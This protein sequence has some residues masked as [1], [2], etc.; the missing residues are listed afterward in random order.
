MSVLSPYIFKQGQQVAHDL[1]KKTERSKLTPRREP[2]WTRLEIG[3]YLGYRVMSDNVG[4]WIARRQEG[5]KKTY[6]ALGH[7]DLY[8]DAKKAALAWAGRVDAG[9]TDKAPTVQAACEHYVKHQRTAKGDNAAK[10]AEGRFKRLVYGTAFGKITLDKLNT[11]KVRAWRDGQI[12]KGDDFDDDTVRRAKDSINRN[13]ATLKA[14]LNLAHRDRLT[15]SD[16]AWKTVTSFEK[17][18][19][20]RTI[21]L[22]TDQR[23]AL[24]AQCG[25]GLRELVTA[26]LLTGIRPGE[27]AGCDVA[28]FDKI[29]GTLTIRISK[30]EARTVPLSTAAIEHFKTATKDRIGAAPLIPDGFGKRWNKDAWKKPFKAAVVAAGLPEKTVMYTLRHCAI[31]ELIAGGMD[32]HL[33]AKIAGTSTA[34]IDANY[35]H[36]RV[37]KTRALMDKTAML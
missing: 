4:T 34:M 37:D 27:L 32:S 33:V 21:F 28:D 35:G 15:A 8:D 24:V 9:V 31:T 2:Y 10:D 1:T 3:L 22:N 13:L 20:R 12:P 23:R 36:L 18:G 16:D 17:V 14:A 29:T 11:I 30:T 26:L 7:H 25:D 6:Q 5:T 19:K